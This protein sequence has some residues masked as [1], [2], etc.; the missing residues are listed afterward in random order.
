MR[1]IVTSPHI[2]VSSGNSSQL[3]LSSNSN[4][5]KGRRILIATFLFL[6]FILFFLIFGPFLDSYFLWIS[7]EDKLRVYWCYRLVYKAELPFSIDPPLRIPSMPLTVALLYFVIV[8]RF[9][10]FKVLICNK[11][12]HHYHLGILCLGIAAVFLMILTLKMSVIENPET[13]MFFWRK[14]NIFVILKGTSFIFLIGGMAFLVLDARDLYLALK[15][16]CAQTAKIKDRIRMD[17][18]DKRDQSKQMASA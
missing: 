13:I 5:N 7:L 15:S 10:N 14:T 16:I 17:Q 8:S 2:C 1:I 11:R 9:L 18:L 12:I 4:P 3:E 6:L